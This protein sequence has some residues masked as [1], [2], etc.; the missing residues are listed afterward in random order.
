[1]TMSLPLARLRG[2]GC[3]FDV[4][5]RRAGFDS[6]VASSVKRRDPPRGDDMAWSGCRSSPR[7]TRAKAVTRSAACAA[8][9]APA[10]RAAPDH[11]AF[12]QRVADG[13]PS[14]TMS[15]P[16]STSASSN[17]RSSRGGIAGIRNS[18]N[19]P[20]LLRHSARHR[21]RNGSSRFPGCAGCAYPVSAPRSDEQDRCSSR[22]SPAV[23][24]APA[25]GSS[26][27]RRCLPIVPARRRRRARGRIAAEYPRPDS[28]DGS[29]GPTA[30]N[31]A[32][33]D[34]PVSMICPSESV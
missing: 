23:G 10:A 24:N 22:S 8:H 34:R 13:M 27:S 25:R 28:L 12:R 26:K 17:L 11:R 18:P 2:I 32:R 16:P 21:G 1:M 33:R 15:A 20:A 29:S 19:S 14:S 4:G 6:R 3:S 30:D 9:P 31:R 7:R 5:V